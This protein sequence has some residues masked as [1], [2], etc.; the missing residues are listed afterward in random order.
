MQGAERNY[1]AVEFEIPANNTEPHEVTVDS[2][3]NGWASQRRGGKL[4][5]PAVGIVPVQPG[6]AVSRPCRPGEAS[7]RS[8]TISMGVPIRGVQSARQ[9]PMDRGV[10]A[11]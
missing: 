2:D 5:G 4:V 1:V 10:R 11:A 3:G 8:W 7:I 9:R 6:A